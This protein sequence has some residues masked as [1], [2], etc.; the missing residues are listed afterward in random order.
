MSPATGPPG[1]IL[2]AWVF[3]TSSRFSGPFNLVGRT[4]SV[5]RLGTCRWRTT[6]WVD[7]RGRE[8]VVLGFGRKD[9]LDMA[10]LQR[11]AQSILPYLESDAAQEVREEH[12]LEAPF[13]FLGAKTLGTPNEHQALQLQRLQVQLAPRDSPPQ[14]GFR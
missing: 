8:Q 9:Q 7:G 4:R 10:S 13:E 2:P 6:V 5:E 1:K 11:L 14:F 3:L 12:G